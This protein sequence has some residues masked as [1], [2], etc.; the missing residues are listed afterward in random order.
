MHIEFRGTARAGSKAC[1]TGTGRAGGRRDRSAR[2]SCFAH[3][4]PHRA[5]RCT[6]RR[7]FRRAKGLAAS[8]ARCCDSTSAASDRASASSTTAAAKREDFTAALDFMAARYPGVPMWAAGCLV[9][10]VGRARDRR[11]RSARVGA[12]R[13]RA[14][15]RARRLRLSPHARDDE[16][17]VLRPGRSRRT[18]SPART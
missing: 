3:P 11:R 9:R 15:G 5:A 18:M 10:L 7:C 4:H 1:S 14:A 2:P 8:A 17:E 16:A 13:H 12:H 6:P